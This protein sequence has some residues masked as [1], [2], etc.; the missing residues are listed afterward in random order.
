MGVKGKWGL[1]EEGMIG[2]VGD[3]GTIFDYVK[4][5]F[6]YELMVRMNLCTS[7]NAACNAVFEL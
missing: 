7:C 6:L 5:H 3:G 4:M 1:G 2:L